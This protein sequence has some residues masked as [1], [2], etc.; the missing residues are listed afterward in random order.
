MSALSVADLKEMLKR[1]NLATTGVKVELVKR[2]MDAGVSA[3]ALSIRGDVPD[4]TPGTKSTEPQPGT[5]DQATGDITNREIEILRRERELATREIE[6]LRRELEL[7]R[8]A[9]SVTGGAAARTSVKKWQELKDLVGEFSGNNLDFDRW[10]KQI[11]KLLAA[12]DLDDHE[13]KA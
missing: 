13:A 7:L 12:Y 2:L 6:L 11:N 5:S 3:E 4:E 10:D 9:Q 1:M 8:T